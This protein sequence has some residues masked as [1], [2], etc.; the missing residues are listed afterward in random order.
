MHWFK[1]LYL[2][3]CAAPLRSHIEQAWVGDIEMAWIEQETALLSLTD[4]ETWIIYPVFSERTT[5]IDELQVW[6]ERERLQSPLST[7]R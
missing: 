4:P 1:K 2:E 3:A 7:K 5:Y 6:M